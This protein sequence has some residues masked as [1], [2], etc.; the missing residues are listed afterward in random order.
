MKMKRIM[1]V[2]RYE[3]RLVRRSW[4]FLIFTIL[5]II[6]IPCIQFLVGDISVAM[7]YSLNVGR[8][9]WNLKALPSFIPYMNAYFFNGMQVLMIVFFVS[10]IEKRTRITTME[11]LW[12]RPATTGELMWG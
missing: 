12:T 5:G 11:P 8:S 7:K 10:E 1:T 6:G 2:A 4:I 9:I 3:A